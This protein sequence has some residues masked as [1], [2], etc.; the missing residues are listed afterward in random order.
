[1]LKNVIAGAALLLFANLAFCAD[2]GFSLV[3]GYGFDWLKPQSTRCTKITAKEA[4]K[5]KNCDYSKEHAFGLDMYA[6]AC[7]V[8][9]RSEFIV[10]KTKP[11][12]QD[13]FETMQANAP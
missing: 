1:M 9:A 3:G 10:L 8:N 11:Q 6:Y 7:R 12:C 5:F 4:E 2:E 13:A